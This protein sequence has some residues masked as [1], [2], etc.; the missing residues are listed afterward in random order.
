MAEIAAIL[1]AAGIFVAGF[2]AW[3]TMWHRR[4]AAA[5]ERVPVGTARLGASVVMRRGAELRQQPLGPQRPG[6]PQASR[7]NSS[8]IF[9]AS[10][11]RTPFL[12][13]PLTGT[14]NLDGM[15]MRWRIGLAAIVAAVVIGGFV[16]H[17]VLSAADSSVT[18]VVQIAEAPVSGSVTCVDATCGK[19]SPAPAAPS[20]GISLVA[21]VGGL[22]GV[23]AAAASSAA[24][25]DGSSPSPQGARDPLYHPP[26]FS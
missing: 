8:R 4:M 13:G 1:G 17:G 11:P 16:P 18:Q 5:F 21:V 10:V 12:M 3:Y 19:G 15:S 25:G 23:A 2:V 24:G 14:R 26:Q 9:R 22:V 6:D 20:P 7:R